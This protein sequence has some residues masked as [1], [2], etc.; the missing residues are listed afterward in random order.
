METNTIF[1][2]ILS[3]KATFPKKIRRL[4]PTHTFQR[5]HGHEQVDLDE[6]DRFHAPSVRFQQLIDMCIRMSL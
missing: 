4:S 3:K 5:A 1:I 2:E 6:L